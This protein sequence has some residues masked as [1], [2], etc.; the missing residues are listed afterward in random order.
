MR[1]VVINDHGV[2]L[3]LRQPAQRVRI[4]AALHSQAEA[5]Q[6]GGE[7]IRCL[8]VFANQKRLKCHK[9]ALYTLQTWLD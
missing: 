1:I 5:R 8:F 9:Q 3:L 7:N 6:G 4:P 2:E